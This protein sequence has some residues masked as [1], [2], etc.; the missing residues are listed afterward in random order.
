VSGAD[1][2]ERAI[3]KP[4]ARNTI[5]RHVATYKRLLRRHA[6]E[7]AVHRFLGSHVYFFNSIARHHV[8]IYSKVKFGAEF[9]ADFAFYDPSSNG[10]EWYFVEI[11][12][13]SQRPFTKAGRPS[14]KLTHAIE[15]ARDWNMWIRG[16][17][18]YS[19]RQ[20]PLIQ[21]PL[22]YVFMGRSEEIDD[23]SRERIR[24]MNYDNRSWLEI[25]SLDRFTSGAESARALGSLQLNAYSQS[26][27][28]H[29]LPRSDFEWLHSGNAK[30]MKR[31]Y[32]RWA[33]EE[34]TAG[35]PADFPDE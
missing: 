15:Q 30:D 25:G 7:A 35:R 24:Q 5:N 32:R 16:N 9:E 8:P 22:F 6:S 19:R 23:A 31:F 1:R 29:G 14:A 26:D 20:F 11:E 17:L 4:I 28:S 2:T 21:Y 3:L 10:A 34:R 18:A 12:A 27:L 13:P 33:M